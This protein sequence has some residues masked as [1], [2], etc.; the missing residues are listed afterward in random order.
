MIFRC[1]K[2]DS[3]LACLANALMLPDSFRCL[4]VLLSRFLGVFF[5]ASRFNV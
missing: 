1:G 4:V 3:F 2:G 5:P